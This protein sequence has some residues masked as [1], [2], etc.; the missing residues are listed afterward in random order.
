M[1]PIVLVLMAGN[2]SR[3]SQVGYTLPKPLISINGKPMIEH[4]VNSVNIDADWV[5]FVQKQHIDKFQVDTVLQSIKP[6]CTVVSTDHVTDGAAR[7]ALLACSKGNIDPDRPLF[8]LNSDNI[9]DWD[10]QQTVDQFLASALDG[11]ILVFRDT[12]PK[13]SFAK[14]NEQGH[15]TEVAEKNPISDLATAGLYCWRRASAFLTA[16]QQMIAKD[17]RVKGEFYLCPVYN[18][19]ITLGHYVGVSHVIKMHGVG[20]PEDLDIYLKYIKQ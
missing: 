20:T 1:K 12:D 7:S 15:V 17:I 5:F 14:V 6:G 2:G 16:A 4:V 18:E 19:N 8:I 10:A 9:L 3:F 13:W 11:L